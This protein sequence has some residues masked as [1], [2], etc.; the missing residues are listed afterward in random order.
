VQATAV[1]V[2]NEPPPVAAPP[3]VDTKKLRKE[4]RAVAAQ[5]ESLTLKVVAA[6]SKG[7]GNCSKVTGNLRALE[8]T[9]ASARTAIDSAKSRAEADDAFRVEWEQALDQIT[10]RMEPK[11]GELKAKVGACKDDPEVRALLG[12]V[13]PRV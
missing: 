2:A 11:L 5:L 8:K 10:K 1:A 6:F 4:A 7:K 9:A 3:P 12:A 13:Y